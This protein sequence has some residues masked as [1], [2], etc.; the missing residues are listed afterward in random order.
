[1]HLEVLGAGMRFAESD[2]LYR[3]VIDH[4]Q[5]ISNDFNRGSHFQ[6]FEVF[7]YAIEGQIIFI[8]DRLTENVALTKFIFG[9]FDYT[10]GIINISFTIT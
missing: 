6:G 1:M 9:E 5:F 10:G 7:R 3:N 2:F 4:C 8:N